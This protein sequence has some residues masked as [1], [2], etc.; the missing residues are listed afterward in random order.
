MKNADG[1]EEGARGGAAVLRWPAAME[2]R[3]AARLGEGLE[4][5]CSRRRGRSGSRWRY[6]ATST[7]GL[8]WLRAEASRRARTAPRR[9]GVMA[10]QAVHGA[11]RV[12]GARCHGARPAPLSATMSRCWPLARA[13]LRV[14]A[15]GRDAAAADHGRR[16][17][18]EAGCGVME[19]DER[20][21]RHGWRC[22]AACCHCWRDAGGAKH[23]GGCGSGSGWPQWCTVR[24]ATSSSA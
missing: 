20:R 3:L 16:S 6:D 14:A 23:G 15:A 22:A 12:L 17:D 19:R 2:T 1:Q 21:L 13:R 5:W 11:W 8:L 24:C 4:T 9:H 10:R 7:A 18:V